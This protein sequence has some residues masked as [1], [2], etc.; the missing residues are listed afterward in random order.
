M[1]NLG[2]MNYLDLGEVTEF[3]WFLVSNTSG[4]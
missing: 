3:L 1:E 2:G 4:S